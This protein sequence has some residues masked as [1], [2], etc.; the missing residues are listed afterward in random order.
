MK[1]SL[2]INVLEFPIRVSAVE[3]LN[4]YRYEAE[5]HDILMVVAA[6]WRE[7][8]EPGEED[9]FEELGPDEFEVNDFLDEFSGA[10]FELWVR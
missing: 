8:P 6:N 2:N 1:L 3:A 5:K 10:T 7:N 9:W 4:F